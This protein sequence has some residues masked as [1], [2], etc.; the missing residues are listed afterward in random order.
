MM[1]NL[2]DF[3]AAGFSETLLKKPKSSVFG[4]AKDVQAVCNTA[5][6]LLRPEEWTGIRGTVGPLA[7][8][9]ASALPTATADDLLQ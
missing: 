2:T 5:W 1:Q 9:F 7:K 4:K 8:A 3:F 6:R